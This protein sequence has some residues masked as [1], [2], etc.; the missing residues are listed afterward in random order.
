MVEA[1]GAA[2][3]PRAVVVP[4]QEALREAL[5]GARAA[6]LALAP[7]LPPAGHGAALAQHVVMV[8]AADIMAAVQ[9]HPTPLVN[10]EEALVLPCLWAR[11]HLPS[12]PLLRCM[13]PTRTD[14]L[15][16]GLIAITRAV[17]MRL[18]QQSAGVGDI[19]LAA[20][21]RTTT[22]ITSML[23]RTMRLPRNWLRCQETAVRR[24]LLTAP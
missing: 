7:A 10:D 18:I 12:S 3:H 8:M 1:V 6:A 5:L 21:T 2:Q 17:K 19:I 13:E 23:S 9:H 24:L 14:I 20:A 15:T 16:I 11:V 4:L 22:R